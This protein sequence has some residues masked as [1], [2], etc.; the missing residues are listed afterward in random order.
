ML[1]SMGKNGSNNET[2]RILFCFFAWENMFRGKLEKQNLADIEKIHKTT[3]EKIKKE[4]NNAK[5]NMLF[6]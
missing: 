2:L 4:K 3:I 6:E 1:A 5:A